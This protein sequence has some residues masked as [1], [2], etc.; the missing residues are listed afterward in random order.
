MAEYT[1]V[2]EQSGRDSLAVPLGSPRM[3]LL[4]RF[5]AALIQQNNPQ[6]LHLNIIV[7]SS[8]QLLTPSFQRL[9]E[10]ELRAAFGPVRQLG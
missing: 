5:L 7:A 8:Q 2:L 9:S 6:S 4:G 10:T 3:V 1:R